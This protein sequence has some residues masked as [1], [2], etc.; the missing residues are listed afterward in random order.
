[1]Q[2]V[3]IVYWPVKFVPTPLSSQW[4]SP[5]NGMPHAPVL[6]RR[7]E[8]S[9][10]CPDPA[11]V[12]LKLTLANPSRTLPAAPSASVAEPVDIELKQ[13]LPL[14]QGSMLVQGLMAEPFLTTVHV[15]GP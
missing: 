4:S 9:W 7:M 11:S 6:N 14:A 10:S 12:T 8:L 13:G 15:T 2:G 3:L 5:C 1:M